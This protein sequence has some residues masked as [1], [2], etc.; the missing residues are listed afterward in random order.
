[1]HLILKMEEQ[2]HSQRTRQREPMLGYTEKITALTNIVFTYSPAVT[3]P[4]AGKYGTSARLTLI[5]PRLTIPYA[6]PIG[7]IEFLEKVSQV[8][9]TDYGHSTSIP[10]ITEKLSEIFQEYWDL[11][12]PP[13]GYAVVTPRLSLQNTES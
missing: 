9:R 12:L 1:M 11:N 4:I 8:I 7:R 3:V 2:L 6:E 5:V 13:R 10:L